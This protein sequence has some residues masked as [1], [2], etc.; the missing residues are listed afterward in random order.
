MRRLFAV[1]IISAT[2]G[3]LGVAAPAMADYPPSTTTTTQAPGTQV[4]VSGSTISV[5]AAT[6]TATVACPPS[7]FTA[8]TTVQVFI[9]GVFYGSVL[10]NADG[11]ITLSIVIT[12]P[13]ISINGG[14]AMAV[15]GT[16]ISVTSSG[17]S[18][19]STGTATFAVTVPIPP[20]FQTAASS[21]STSSSGSLAF[22]GLDI[23]GMTAGAILL[24]GA[25]TVLVV[26]TRR[27]HSQDT[28]KA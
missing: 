9:N 24:L 17:A 18:G 22:T 27:R 1:G 3:V 19:T 7:T 16:S 13:H 21:S 11:S 8:G 12:D 25:G 5:N 28:P 15:T 10:A 6:G 20:A 4:V 26:F 23:L 14:P 2:L